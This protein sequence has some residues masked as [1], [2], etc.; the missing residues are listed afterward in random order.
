MERAAIEALLRAGRTV[1]TAESCT[2]GLIAARLVNVPGASGALVE[3]H[4]TY[5]N[6]AKMRVLGVPEE[7]LA[8]HGA[9]SEATA[10]AMAEGL[11]KVSGADICL[12]VTGVAGPGGG[13]AE[14]PVGLVYL[15]LATAAGAKVRRLQLTGDR[16]RI[17]TLATLYGLHW[18]L[19]ATQPM[20]KQT[21]ARG[22][23][24]PRLR[25]IKQNPYPAKA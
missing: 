19:E 4:V 17:R 5:A 10:R 6:E 13:S 1:A 20:I 11:R 15:G 18:I 2:G 21:G 23:K 8:R 12:S 22:Q 16:E 9:V 7:T 3:G 24:T 25:A 14:K